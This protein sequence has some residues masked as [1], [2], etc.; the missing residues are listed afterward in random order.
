M[1]A[2]SLFVGY[3]SFTEWLKQHLYQ[4]KTICNIGQLLLPLS[5]SEWY[6][7]KG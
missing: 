4:I 1:G 5:Y 6:G 3:R 7:K 2:T